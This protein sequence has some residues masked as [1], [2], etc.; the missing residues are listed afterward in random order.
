MTDELSEYDRNWILELLDSQEALLVRYC[1]KLTGNLEQS[2]EIVQQTWLKLI[3][4]DDLRMI[5]SY[6]VQWL[7]TVCRNSCMDHLRKVGNVDSLE[8]IQTPSALI[9]DDK[10]TEINEIFRMIKS[11]PAS[12]QEVILLK[13]Q[14]GFS[15]KEI[16][17]ITGHSI[18]NVGFLIHRGI[19]TLRGALQG[20]N[21]EENL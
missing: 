7:Y 6:A 12:Q 3:K 14:E 17:K 16:S 13:F 5:K 21:E 1:F 15:Y 10:T 19:S 20:Q 4:R 11:L 9:L 8:D 2:K 18:S